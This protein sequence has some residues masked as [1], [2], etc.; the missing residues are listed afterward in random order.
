M[1]RVF[2]TRGRR[3][4]DVTAEEHIRV[5]ATSQDMTDGA[6]SKTVNVSPDMPWD[7]FKPLYQDAYDRGCKG[8]T[9]YTPVREDG[10][11]GK[12]EGIL[13]STDAPS[14][15]IDPTTGTRSCE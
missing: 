3:S 10:T 7:E 2:G 12:R 15:S 13:V 5:L 11:G 1:V 4:V 6:C 9:T 14:C 8:M